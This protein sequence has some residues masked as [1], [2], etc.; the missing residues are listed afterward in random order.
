MTE[1]A[2]G[3]DGRTFSTGVCEP[4]HDSLTYFFSLSS[5]ICFFFFFLVK[6]FCLNVFCNAFSFEIIIKLNHIEVCF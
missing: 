3:L 6:L 2:E 4:R 5:R 1:R